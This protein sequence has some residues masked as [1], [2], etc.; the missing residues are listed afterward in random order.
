MFDLIGIGGRAVM[1]ASTEAADIGVS[2]GKVVAI[3]APGTL[4]SVG[5]GRMAY[6]VRRA[7]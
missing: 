7:R 3:E 6:T 1:P 4:A 5:A 2:G